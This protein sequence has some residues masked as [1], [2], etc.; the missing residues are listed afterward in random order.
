MSSPPPG[1]ARRRNTGKLW[2]AGLFAG[3]LALFLCLGCFAA[4]GLT[5]ILVYSSQLAG[6]GGT[7]TISVAGPRITFEPA[8]STPTPFPPT[9]TPATPEGGPAPGSETPVSPPPAASPTPPVAEVTPVAK[10]VLDILPPPQI[11]QRETTAGMFANLERLRETTYPAHDFYESAGRLG[12]IDMGERT[13][14]TDPA[15][16]GEQRE[17]YVDGGITNATLAAETEH[18]YFWV[19][20]GLDLDPNALQEAADRFEN[21]YYAQIVDLIGPAWSP[22][23][24]GDPHFSVLHLVGSLSSADELGYFSSG[25]EL[26]ATFYYDSNEQEIVYLNMSNLSL[27]E[28]L[29]FGTLVHEFQHLAHWY[30]DANETAWMDEGLAQ[31]VE[32][33]VGL[34]TADFRDYLAVPETR[35]N[36]W[37]YDDDVYAHYSAA[38]LFMVYLW[39]Q[40]G[41]EAIRELARHPANGLMAVE[42]ALAGFRPELSLQQFVANWA[43]ANLIDDA[44]AGPEYNYQRLDLTSVRMERNVRNLPLQ[45]VT[46]LDQFGVHYVDLSFE[47]PVTI[48]FAGDTTTELLPVSPHEGTQMW[49]A[50][51]TD[52]V[53]AQLTGRFDLRGLDQATLTF[54]TWFVL[55]EDYDYVYLSIS[56]DGGQ[57]WELLVPD[58]ARP[59]DYG[60]AFT[61]QSRLHRGA[62]NEGWLPVEVSLNS[63]VG[64]EVLIRFEMLTNSPAYGQGLALDAIEIPELGFLS[65]AENADEGW[66][67]A[68]FA[69]VGQWLPQLWSVQLVSFGLTP[70]VYTLP[71]DKLNQGQWSFELG[72]NGGTL[73]ITPLTPFAS[74]AARY[75]LA[76]EQ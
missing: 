58:K 49:Y 40:L 46:S 27:G 54:W 26:P 48:S 5:G 15:S 74:N 6:T 24:D 10:P 52:A 67:S 18:A 31:L 8:T 60:P 41:E 71:L 47:G 17:F 55:E 20:E 38:Y 35:L 53:D 2:A 50:P 66:E 13:I 68:G 32:L 64:R 25:D 39:E 45:M 73:I 30:I 21:E 65:G 28:D 44:D 36:S 9:I 69:P 72:R 76:L 4:L 37:S 3:C 23:M 75:W 70:E 19:E 16:I 7:P 22:G 33:Y 42:L 29:Y 59:G 12:S 56:S 57:S 11:D 43:A 61:G 34:E 63:Y 1:A 62:D 14:V 51:P